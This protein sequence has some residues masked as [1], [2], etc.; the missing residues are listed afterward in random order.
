MPCK[1]ASFSIEA[2]LENLKGVRLLALF[3]EM[4][5]KSEYS[6]WSRRLFRF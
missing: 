6:T 3:R 1:R 2:L 5:S 4:N